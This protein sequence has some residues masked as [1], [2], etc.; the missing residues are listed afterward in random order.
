M[1]PFQINEE[2]FFTL[3]RKKHSVQNNI[4]LIYQEGENVGDSDVS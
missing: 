1:E 3:L 2:I 4:H